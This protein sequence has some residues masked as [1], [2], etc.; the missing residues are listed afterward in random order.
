MKLCLIMGGAEEGGLENHVLILCNNFV[1]QFDVSLI[2]HPMY[3]DR[4]DSRVNFIPMPMDLGRRNPWLLTRLFLKLKA[5]SPDLIHTH[6]NKATAIFA[7]IKSWIKTP[8]IATVHNVK[9]RVDMFECMAGVIGV[10]QGVV[11]GVEH[12]RKKV[13]YNGVDIFEGQAQSKNALIE[14]WQLQPGRK[15]CLAIGRLVPAKAYHLLISA[16]QGIDHN[17]AIVGEGP[18]QKKLQQLIDDLKL[19]HKIKLVGFRDDIRAILPA[20]DL[21]TISSEREGFSLVLIE[22]L[23]AETP[24]VSTTVAGSREILPSAYLCSTGDVDGF[25]AIAKRALEDEESLTEN[26]KPVFAMAKTR[27]TTE[28]MLNETMNYY[29][30]IISEIA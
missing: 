6:G 13:I 15:L 5:L 1:E 23:L 27:L 3:K 17:L 25:T 24:V 11:E 8:C 29:R 2:A 22:A 12:V 16:W 30:N 10:S 4:L 26:Y 21:L 7:S 20:A 9:R 18:E 14:E 19:G 28:A